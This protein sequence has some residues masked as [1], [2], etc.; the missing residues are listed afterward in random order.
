MMNT[1]FLQEFAA[2][3]QLS[4]HKGVGAA[5]FRRLL[6]VYRLPSLALAS[7]LADGSDKNPD[8]QRQSRLKSATTL[9]IK[10][11]LDKVGSG[12]FLGWYYSQTGYPQQLHDL[13]EPPPVLFG[14]SEIRPLRF[15]AVVGARKLSPEAVR[16][17]EEMV[18]QLV[19]EGYAIVSGGALGADTVA[20]KKALDLGAYTAAILATGLD[21][22][23]PVTN[24]SLFAEIARSGVLLSE[25]MPGAKPQRSFFPARNRII[26]ALADV[27]AIVQADAGSGALITAAWASRLGRRLLVLA[28][29]TDDAE[30]WAGNIQL[31]EAGAGVYRPGGRAFSVSEPVSNFVH[32]DCHLFTGI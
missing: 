5:A 26:A 10:N 14:S 13:G 2:A 17:A 29:Q 19:K 6:D 12:E 8:L 32:A 25:M 22:V 20:H 3:L 11:A 28:P 9:L 18:C 24:A 30:L 15:A 23:Y 27:V 16:P 31:I 21:I 7:W 1:T 4:R